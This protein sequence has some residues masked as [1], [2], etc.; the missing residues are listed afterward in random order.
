[1]PER[2]RHARPALLA[3]VAILAADAFIWARNLGK[4]A[5]F[6]EGSYTV[7]LEALRDGQELGKE[8]FL[9]QPPLFYNL[10]QA[11]GGL[12]GPSFDELR[13]GML[14]VSLVGVVAAF[15]L[16]RALA[17]DWAGLGA[18]ALYSITPPFPNN[19]PLIEADPPSVTLALVALAIAAHGYGRGRHGALSFLAGAALAASI[20]VKLFTVTAF[21]PL[22]A[23]AVWRRASVRQLLLTAAGGVAL[24]VLTVLPHLGALPELWEGVVGGHLDQRTIE[25]PSHLD[26]ARRVVEFFDPRTPATYLLLAGLAAYAWR[27]PRGIWTLW[28]WSAAAIA[29]TIAMRPL[30]DHHLVLLAAALAVTAGAALGEA[31]ASLRRPAR[32]AAVALATLIALAGGA[33]QYRQASRNNVDETARV[34]WAAEVIKRETHPGE[35]IVTDIP[36]VAVLADRRVPGFLV[37]V[38]WGRVRSGALNA[39]NVIE[40]IEHEGIDA[41]VV[42]RMLRVSPGLAEELRARFPDRRHFETVTIYLR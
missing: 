19:A 26:N 36:T 14:V 20:L 13:A 5:N 33:Q 11:L 40:T 32:V 30:L 31:I 1:M 6:D 27:R 18:A 42:G 16:G 39:Q 8:V 41:V 24:T 23:L 22:V 15:A 38:S 2:L 10:L 28:S 35:R 17:G 37:D 12:I 3:L 7:A 34:L 4:A 29:F 25:A 21:V 9:V